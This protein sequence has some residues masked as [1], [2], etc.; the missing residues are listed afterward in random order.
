MRQALIIVFHY[1]L[2]WLPH[3]APVRRT[4]PASVKPLQV[5]LVEPVAYPPAQLGGEDGN[6][7]CNPSNHATSPIL[8]GLGV[9]VVASV[10]A[11][12]LM[13]RLGP[14]RTWEATP[15]AASLA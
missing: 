12:G 7:F 2:L 8:H 15:G 4:T 5:A 13:T 10:I 9:F 3:Q 14:Y 11:A 6:I 1:V